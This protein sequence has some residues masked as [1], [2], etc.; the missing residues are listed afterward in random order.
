MELSAKNAKLIHKAVKYYLAKIRA[1]QLEICAAAVMSELHTDCE[2]SAA[3][4]ME[5]EEFTK[6][7]DDLETWQRYRDIPLND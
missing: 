3:I 4:E 1:T 5:I 2:R 7:N 6:L